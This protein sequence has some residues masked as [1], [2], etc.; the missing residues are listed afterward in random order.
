MSPRGGVARSTADWAPAFPPNL[1]PPAA[2]ALNR[3]FVLPG[4]QVP[5]APASPPGGTRHRRLANAASLAPPRSRGPA[6][7]ASSTPDTVLPR[8]RLRNA[9]P[10]YPDVTHA[11]PDF[12]CPCPKCH[13]LSETFPDIPFKTAAFPLFPPSALPLPVHAFSPWHISNIFTLP[14]YGLSLPHRTV[15]SMRAGTMANSLYD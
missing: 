15:T 10:R 4:A 11:V 2:V 12:L 8:H 1:P 14:I 7:R 13:F 3:S 6:R 9:S 5:D